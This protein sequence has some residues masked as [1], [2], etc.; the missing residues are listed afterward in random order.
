MIMR[1]SG[2]LVCGG[3]AACGYRRCNRLPTSEKNDL[4]N[5][6]FTMLDLGSISLH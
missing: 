2:K 1:E 5:Y 3:E 4:W 6:Y